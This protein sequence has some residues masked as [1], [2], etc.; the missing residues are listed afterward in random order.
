MIETT[1]HVT[2]EDLRR[3]GRTDML[4]KVT[5]VFIGIII[6]GGLGASL[7]INSNSGRAR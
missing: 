5:E 2:R 3:E 1:S 4:M 7:L 6:L